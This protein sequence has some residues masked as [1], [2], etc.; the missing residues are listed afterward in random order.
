MY[1][2]LGEAVDFARALAPEVADVHD[3]DILVCP[4]FV[5]IHEVARALAGTNVMVGA[6]NV[7][8][9]DQGAFTGEVSA[10]M[11]KSA[12]AVCAIVGHSERR[13]HFGETDRV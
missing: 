4:S 12:G 9:E 3:R 6:Q 8:P 11:L 5:C 13:Q 2:G 10:P 1:K 7:H